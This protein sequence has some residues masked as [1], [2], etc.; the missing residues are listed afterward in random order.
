MGRRP[1]RKTGDGH[2]TTIIDY[3]RPQKRPN[4]VQLLGHTLSPSHSHHRAKAAHN[5]SGGQIPNVSPQVVV[6]DINPPEKHWTGCP[7]PRTRSS[8]TDRLNRDGRR[9]RAEELASRRNSPQRL[10]GLS[11][12]KGNITE[13]G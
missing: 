8:R 13:D 3:Q 11:V 2:A 1:V 12:V 9:W 7:P 5:G 6:L 4:N 10:E